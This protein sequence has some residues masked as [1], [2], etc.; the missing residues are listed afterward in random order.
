MMA[1]SAQGFI[2]Y[3]GDIFTIYKES[4]LNH[5]HVEFYTYHLWL[6]YFQS[7]INAKYIPLW[8]SGELPYI[9]IW[10][11]QYEIQIFYDDKYD[12][13]LLKN[14]GQ[15][16]TDSFPIDI[17]TWLSAKGYKWNSYSDNQ[18]N[19]FYNFG[20]HFDSEEETFEAVGDLLE[21]LK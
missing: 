7:H 17:T 12:I 16:S 11:G 15:C 10:C 9:K 3:D 13:C 4:R 19:S 14:N 1:Y 2:G 21:K 6:K 8:Y 20:H 5:Y 18:N